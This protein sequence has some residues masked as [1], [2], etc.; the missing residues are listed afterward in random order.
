MRRALATLAVAC[1]L[2]ACATGRT[3]APPVVELTGVYTP[4]FETS[5]FAP[6]DARAGDAGWWVIL[7]A[8]ALRQRDGLRARLPDDAARTV[9]VRWRAV[10][11]HEAATGC[12]AALSTWRAVP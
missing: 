7:S 8:D 10:L 12:A 1:A 6:C 9:Y 4:G 2:A 11:G 5:R 3:S